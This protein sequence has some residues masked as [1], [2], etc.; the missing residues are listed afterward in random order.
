MFNTSSISKK[1][2]IVRKYLFYNPFVKNSFPSQIRSYN[3]ESIVKNKPGGIVRFMYKSKSIFLAE[4]E[5]SFLVLPD[6]TTVVGVDAN[7]PSTLISEDITVNDPITFAYHDCNIYTVLYE[8]ITNTL[9]VGD[10]NSDIVQYFISD[11]DNEFKL[12]KEYKGLEIGRVTSSAQFGNFVAFGGTN[13]KLISIHLLGKFVLEDNIVVAYDNINSLCVCKI[14]SEKELLSVSGEDPS[15][16]ESFTNIFKTKTETFYKFKPDI[17]TSNNPISKSN[18]KKYPFVNRK[19]MDTMVEILAILFERFIP[20]SY[21]NQQNNPEKKGISI[22]YYVNTVQI[23]KILILFQKKISSKK[24]GES[25]TTS[26]F[27]NQV[28][29]F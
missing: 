3:L 23:T 26:S 8:N 10:E 15:D 20:M 11:Q 1:K 18:L 24:S 4:Y 13:D 19:M 29:E 12:L 17:F 16:F 27:S 25:S 6:E 9:F 2:I 14:D 28:E 22:R 5:N 7:N 21:F